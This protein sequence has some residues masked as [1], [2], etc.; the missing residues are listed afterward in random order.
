MTL[1]DL[2]GDGEPEL[3]TTSPA[4]HPDA[5]EV[6]VLE[7]GGTPSP[8]SSASEPATAVPDARRRAPVRGG[9]ALQVVGARLGPEKGAQIVVGVWKPDGSG[10]LQVFRQVPR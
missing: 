5:E 2:D 3:V 4:Y 9:W 10:E 6:R 7:L 8:S 1:I